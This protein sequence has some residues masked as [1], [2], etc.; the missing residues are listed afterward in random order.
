MRKTYQIQTI[1]QLNKKIKSRCRLLF[2]AVHRTEPP[3][4]AAENN[5]SSADLDSSPP[6]ISSSAAEDKQTTPESYTPRF[7]AS[8]THPPQYSRV[9]LSL[10]PFLSLS[11]SLIWAEAVTCLFS[12]IV[13]E[14]IDNFEIYFRLVSFLKK[15][16]YLV[17]FKLGGKKRKTGIFCF[18]LFR[19]KRKAEIVYISWLWTGYAD[20]DIISW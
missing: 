15:S 4:P 3:D 20:M 14:W 16:K 6:L 10:N 1:L 19:I 8:Y 7:S 18:P 9:D 5:R 17:T 12:Y 13:C 11:K 2:E